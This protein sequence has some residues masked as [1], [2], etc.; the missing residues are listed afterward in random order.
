MSDLGDAL[1]YL[2]IGESGVEADVPSLSSRA[3]V[4]SAAVIVALVA[5]LIGTSG[6][7]SERLPVYAE[8]G[9]RVIVKESSADIDQPK[10]ANVRAGYRSSVETLCAILARSRAEGRG[11]IEYLV[12]AAGLTDRKD[13]ELPKECS[14]EE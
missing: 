8:T 10:C 13:L 3:F 2:T 5:I 14:N 6:C 9:L 12:G 4:I 11:W 1:D 7:S